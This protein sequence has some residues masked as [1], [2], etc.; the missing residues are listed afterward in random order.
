[1]QKRNN[2]TTVSVV[3]RQ[4]LGN[5]TVH[6]RDEEVGSLGLLVIEPGRNVSHSVQHHPCESPAI[7]QSLVTRI[8][9]A[10]DL[11]LSRNF[12]MYPEKVSRGLLR[13]RD[14]FE[15]KIN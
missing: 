15:L 3:N 1:M 8:I 7:Q 12:F 10:Q 13:Q 2:K 6:G 11:E 14:D 5:S 9:N 4:T